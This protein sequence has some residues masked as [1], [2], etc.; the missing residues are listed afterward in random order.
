M[1]EVS[2]TDLQR[3]AGEVLQQIRAEQQ[4]VAVTNHRKRV[5]IILPIEQYELLRGYVPNERS[6][7][8]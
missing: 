6:F 2:S 5:V 3:N 7:A 8:Y 4:P 1:R